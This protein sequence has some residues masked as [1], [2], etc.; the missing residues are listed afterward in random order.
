MYLST[1]LPIY[2]T[3]TIQL[4]RCD[5]KLHRRFTNAIFQ[6]GVHDVSQ[7]IDEK[8]EHDAKVAAPRDIQL[9]VSNVPK[10]HSRLVLIYYYY[11]VFMYM[12]EVGRYYNTMWRAHALIKQDIGYNVYTYL[13]DLYSRIIYNNILRCHASPD[14]V[15]F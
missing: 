15:Y 4:S 11:Y 7:A 5:I 6:T 1:T 8:L 10:H 13:Y 12:T 2:A 9:W 14:T 3:Y